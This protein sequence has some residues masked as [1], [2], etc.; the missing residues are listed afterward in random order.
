M[1]PLISLASGKKVQQIYTNF[2]ILFGGTAG[3]INYPSVTATTTRYLFT[4]DA[5]TLDRPPALSSARVGVHAVSTALKALVF[6][7]AAWISNGYIGTYETYNFSTGTKGATANMLSVRGLGAG[8]SDGSAL[9]MLFG[10]STAFAQVNTVEQYDFATVTGVANAAT[11]SAARAYDSAASNSSNSFVFNTDSAS[12]VENWMFAAGGTKGV[13]ASSMKSPARFSTAAASNGV[14]KAFVF[15]GY[16]GPYVNS[17]VVEQYLFATPGTKGA[18]ALVTSSTTAARAGMSAAGNSTKAFLFGG[19]IG[20]NNACQTIVETWSFAGA[21]SM[22][23]LAAAL[24]SASA[25]AS[26]CSDHQ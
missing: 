8:S 6:G 22:G 10:G 24:S 23:V 2:A 18:S 13:N 1:P 17:N 15:G 11:I 26:A 5:A 12:I 9:S 16:V 25:Y 14:D 7:G 19:Y 21:G 4:T 3:T 20:S